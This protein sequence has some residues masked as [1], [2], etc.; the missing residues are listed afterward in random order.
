MPSKYGVRTRPP[1]PD[2][3]HS[4]KQDDQQHALADQ[5]QDHQPQQAQRSPASPAARRQRGRGDQP[6]REGEPDQHRHQDHGG[7]GDQP[8]YLATRP[9][10]APAQPLGDV[11]VEVGRGWRGRSPR[12]GRRRSRSRGGRGASR[13]GRRAAGRQHVRDHAVRDSSAS[14]RANRCRRAI[15]NETRATSHGRRGTLS[16]RSMRP[17][18]EHVDHVGAE[19]DRAAERDRVDD[20]AVEEVLVADLGRRQQAR[21]RR[22]W[23]RSRARSGRRE[24]VLGGPLDAGRA[25]LERDGQVLEGHVAELLGQPAA[26]RRGG[27]DVRAGGD[28]PPDRAQRTVAEHL[29]ARRDGLPQVGE[30][31]DR[32]RGDGSRA[33]MAPFRAPTDVPS[34]R[35]GVMPRS[36]RACSMPTSTAPS[37]PP[38]PST[39]AVVTAD[40]RQLG[41]L[42]A[43]PL[44]RRGARPRR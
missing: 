24:P 5:V 43:H 35:S 40:G 32:R 9:G 44:A 14:S 26:H 7:R 23:P 4:P 20:A 38:P 34:T 30:P 28:G 25:H 2:E 21:A 27:V 13:R 1:K 36:N 19:R 15:S 33:T 22:R 41:V 10:V 12:C 8:A 42:G 11:L 39:N 29:A 16:G 37:T 17:D 6:Q 31:L 3:I 18:L